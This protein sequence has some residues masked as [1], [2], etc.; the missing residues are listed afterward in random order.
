MKLNVTKQSVNKFHEIK[1]VHRETRITTSAHYS[2]SSLS[3]KY[4]M[5][6][7]S[8]VVYKLTVDVSYNLSL[9]SNIDFTTDAPC[10]LSVLP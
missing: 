2:L 7:V 10:I 1:K 4:N 3:V 8:V 5:S 6:S 9:L